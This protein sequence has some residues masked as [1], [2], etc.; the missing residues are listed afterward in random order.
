MEWEADKSCHQEGGSKPT[1][2][3]LKVADAVESKP[4]VAV[5]TGLDLR[6]RCSDLWKS[7]ELQTIE[8]KKVAVCILC[9]GKFKYNKG[10]TTSN[11]RSHLC[12]KHAHALA[13]GPSAGDLASGSSQ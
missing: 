9:G 8:A 5:P 3:R 2:K 10:G 6:E 12:V 11:L 13:A 7:F 4:K 1:P